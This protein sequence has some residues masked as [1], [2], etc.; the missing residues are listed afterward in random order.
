MR[1]KKESGEYKYWHTRNTPKIKYSPFIG[2][3]KNTVEIDG[4]L[5]IKEPVNADQII[6][7]IN[8]Y[9]KSTLQAEPYEVTT[10]DK[11]GEETQTTEQVKLQ[12]INMLE[13]SFIQDEWL[14][15]ARSSEDG[16]YKNWRKAKKPQK[17]STT[18]NIIE[19]SIENS[20]RIYV[21]RG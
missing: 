12:S 17:L 18:R 20:G 4:R 3:D 11:N 7:K 15:R 1:G 2:V 19:D 8:F 5:H 13:D 16:K 14:M 6:K 21:K 9:N 10:I